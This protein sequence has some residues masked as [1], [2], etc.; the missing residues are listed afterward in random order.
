MHPCKY[1]CTMHNGIGVIQV[2]ELLYMNTH[3]PHVIAQFSFLP[4]SSFDFVVIAPNKCVCKLIFD[5]LSPPVYNCV[6]CHVNQDKIFAFISPSCEL[7][8]RE[9]KRDL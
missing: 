5:N 6:I 9:E 2:Y 7:R 1:D 8:L 4:T 3:S